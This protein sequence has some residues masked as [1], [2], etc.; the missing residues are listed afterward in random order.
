MGEH[1]GVTSAESASHSFTVR[2]SSLNA[3]YMPA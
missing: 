2:S 1:E 3:L